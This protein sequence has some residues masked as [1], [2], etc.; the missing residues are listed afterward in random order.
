MN[1]ETI[2]HKIDE[3]INLDFGTIFS[4]SF[5]LFKLVWVQGFVTLLLTI[6]CM[7]PFY[8]A[9]YAPMIAMG[10]SD[11]EALESG[12]L[13]PVLMLVMFVVMPI[14]MVVFMMIGLS[15]NA[16]FL[17]ICKHKDLNEMAKDD[18]FYF[19]KGKNLGK[20]FMLSLLVF[21]LSLLGMIA[22]GVGLV[23]M[24]V[25]ISLV[26]A[27]MAFN[28]ELTPMEMI[29]ASFKLGNKNWIVIFGLI[30]VMGFIAQLG[31]FLCFIG[32]LFTAMLSKIP[33]YF[34]YKDGVGFPIEE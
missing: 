7:L 20:L 2:L 25:P 15:L 32:V 30:F 16:A 21:G 19:L 23:Y 24:M 29:K 6:V 5:D 31:M 17:R 3:N 12:A 13:P 26:P 14:F 34:M 33:V 8:L 1:F 27:F 9:M 10:I 18:Y 4:R 28:E 22:C 11:P